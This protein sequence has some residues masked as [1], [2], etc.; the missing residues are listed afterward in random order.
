MARNY[1]QINKPLK[2]NTMKYTIEYQPTIS[3]TCKTYIFNNIPSVFVNDSTAIWGLRYVIETLEE[4]ISQNNEEEIFG[5]KMQD[6][7]ILKQLNIEKVTY[8]EF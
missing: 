6:I 3:E 5:I 7:K 4:E 2:L 1:K 8:I